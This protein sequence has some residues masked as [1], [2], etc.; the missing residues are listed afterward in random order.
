M[1]T[2]AKPMRRGRR[3]FPTGML[4]TPW[5]DA[6]GTNSFPN[7]RTRCAVRERVS[8]MIA[9]VTEINA[10]WWEWRLRQRGACLPGATATAQET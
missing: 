7:E 9:R 3:L 5:P 2:D 6:G 8:G 1:A 4:R 10:G